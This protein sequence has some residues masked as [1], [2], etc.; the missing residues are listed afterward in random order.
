MQINFFEKHLAI[1]KK[2][3]YNEEK[4]KGAFYHG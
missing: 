4:K 3:Q 1:D 2:M